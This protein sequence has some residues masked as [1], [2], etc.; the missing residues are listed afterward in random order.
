MYKNYNNFM[1]LLPFCK[2]CVIMHFIENENKRSVLPPT[3]LHRYFCEKVRWCYGSNFNTNYMVII[4]WINNYYY[5][6]YCLNYCFCNNFKQKIKTH[7][8]WPWKWVFLLSVATHFV[9]LI[10]YLYY[11]YFLAKSQYTYMFFLNNILYLTIWKMLL[12][13][14]SKKCFSFCS[15]LLFIHIFPLPSSR[16]FFF[17]K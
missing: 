8:A 6:S 14:F 9:L 3:Y 16:H 1:F 13:F 2:F 11:T 17:I 15:Y 7:S 5:H 4:L 10:F 12:H